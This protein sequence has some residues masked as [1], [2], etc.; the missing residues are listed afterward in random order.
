MKGEDLF[1]KI[2]AI[3]INEDLADKDT[4]LK[5]IRRFNLDYG[6]DVSRILIHMREKSKEI[7]K[8]QQIDNQIQSIIPDQFKLNYSPIKTKS[9][10]NCLYHMVSLCIFGHINYSSSLRILTVYILKSFKQKF[11]HLVKKKLFHM[12]NTAT[13]QA[14]NQK[15]IEYFNNLINS[16]RNDKSWGGEFHL[17]ALSTIFNSKIYIYG[18]FSTDSFLSSNLLNNFKVDK[19]QTSGNHLFYCPIEIYFSLS[20]DKNKLKFISGYFDS[21]LQHYTAFLPNSTSSIEYPPK[22]SL[23]ENVVKKNSKFTI[24]VYWEDSAELT[25]IDQIKFI[26]NSNIN[27]EIIGNLF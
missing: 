26:N 16:A 1:S 13:K 12:D 25:Y 2:S 3:Y 9:D 22:S 23:F 7:F 8:K 27:N 24:L 21:G 19:N 14:L 15:G 11:I 5:N 6:H 4:Q 18:K 10:G 20:S 17:I